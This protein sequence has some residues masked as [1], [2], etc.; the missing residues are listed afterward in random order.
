[1][2]RQGANLPCALSM[3]SKRELVCGGVSDI[4]PV[5]SIVG[6]T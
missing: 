3:Q 5:Y 2:W 6:A 1:V 4:P